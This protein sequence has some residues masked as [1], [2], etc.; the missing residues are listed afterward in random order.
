MF[1]RGCWCAL[2]G[3]YFKGM[4]PDQVAPAYS[5]GE[6][7]WWVHYIGIDY[8]YGNSAAAAGL[9]AVSPPRLGFPFGQHYKID[10]LIARE[11]LSD[12]FA[13]AV[14]NRFAVR[15]GAG[16]RKIVCAYIDPANNKHEGTG[17]S[18]MEIINETF[19]TFDIPLVPASN[20]PLGG[21]Q[22]LARMLAS[23]QLILT[24]QCP[25][26]YKSLSTRM[27]DKD[28]PGCYKKIKGDHLDDVADE[29]RY[30][31]NTYT[32]QSIAPRDVQIHDQ[33][34]E[35]RK[36]GLDDHSLM[37]YN[38]R[39]QSKFPPDD[40]PATLGSRRRTAIIRR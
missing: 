17:R 5:I 27:H 40:T 39:L 12:E 34:E 21:S 20:D 7:W 11:Q 10:E 28:R 35:M 23:G 6:Q 29:T 13:R 2:Q 14:C 1:L 4:R 31:T 15:I 16:P 32:E 9:Y 3:A 38:H 33:L 8:G 25:E 18:N 30:A 24:D 22:N 19:E 26:T 37:I 36:A